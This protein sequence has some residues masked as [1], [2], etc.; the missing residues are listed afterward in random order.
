MVKTVPQMGWAG[1][2]NGELL[3]KA[4]IDFDV[5]LTNDQNLSAQQN[6]TKY[7]ITVLVLCPSSNRFDDLKIVLQK[8][9]KK[10]DIL[11]PGYAT[12]IK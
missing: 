8:A 12:F 1:L 4:Q 5:F 9:I 6:L 2:T 11:K 10:V 3:I 7:N